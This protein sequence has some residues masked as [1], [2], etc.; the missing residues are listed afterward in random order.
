[1]LGAGSGLDSQVQVLARF[2]E[3]G[4]I[5]NWSS[6]V[7]LVYVEKSGS[8]L[9]RILDSRVFKNQLHHYT[10]PTLKPTFQCKP[11]PKQNPTD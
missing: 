4:Y 7:V 5:A 11:E 6:D 8:G 3:T 9:V 10:H 1:M 2:L